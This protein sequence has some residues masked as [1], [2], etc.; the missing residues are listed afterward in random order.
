MRT[1]I[2]LA[3]LALAVLAQDPVPAPKGALLL[4]DGAKTDGWVHRGNGKPCAWK[5]VDGALVVTPG[6]SDIVSKRNFN[7]ATLHLEFWLPKSPPGTGWQGRSN[8]GVYLQG[9]YE[10][11]ILDSYGV[12]ELRT[13][14]CGSIYGQKVPDRNAARPPETWQTYDI[15]FKAPR[16]KD[17]KRIAKARVTVRWNGVLVHDDVAIDGG[18]TA[19]AGGDPATPGPVLLQNHGNQVR[20]RNVWVAEKTR[21]P[22]ASALTLPKIFADHMVLQRDHPVPVWGK[23]AMAGKDVVVQ[24]AGKEARAKAGRDGKWKVA[25]PKLEAGGPHE[26]IISSGAARAVFTDVLIGEVWVCSGQSNMRMRVDRSNDAKAEVAAARHP[27]IRLATVPNRPLDAPATDA[28]VKWEV[29][30]SDTVGPFSAVAYYFGRHL[31]EHL[32]VPVGLVMTSVGGTPVEAWTPIEVLRDDPSMELFERQLANNARLWRNRLSDWQD[33]AK[34][35]AAEGRPAPKKPRRPRIRR[36][37]RPALLWNGMVAPLVPFAMRGVIWYQGERNT[38]QPLHYERL[39]KLQI[40]TWRK[41]WN[42]GDFPFLF[43]QL[44]N[45]Q[46][47]HE[48]PTNSAWAW[49][50]GAQRGALELP[51]TGMAVTI[52]IGDAKDI[53][54]RNKQAVGRRLGLLARRLVHGHEVVDAGPTLVKNK[55]DGARIVL[56]F[57]NGD[58]MKPREGD[59]LVGFAIAGADREFVWADA[60]IDGSTISVSHPAVKDPVA[61][62]YAWADNPA[63]NLV[64]AA[65]LPASPFRTDDWK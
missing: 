58:G 60:R 23:G 30:T 1:A 17:G 37:H 22:A 4:F 56:E 47:R 42:Q 31:Q 43:V 35:A 26:L 40:N 18:T 34:V 13:G 8:S 24:V 54:P 52:D 21:V 19:N 12:K 3:A 5:V 65:G 57:E 59:T 36:Q 64:N 2:C 10:I 28:E 45:F 39:F 15:D 9:R 51:A 48:S 32:D 62:R 63:C 55:I 41:R 46:R 49:V 44:A 61:V 20:Y 11:Q 33:K 7:D 25:L 29:C 38:R 6:T 27:R 14:D 16:F 50:R 53:H